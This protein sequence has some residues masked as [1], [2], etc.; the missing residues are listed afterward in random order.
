MEDR[1][2]KLRDYIC[3]IDKAVFPQNP[4]PVYFRRQK[5]S[6]PS[7]HNKRH[8]VNAAFVNLIEKTSLKVFFV[9]LLLKILLPLVKFI[10]KYAVLK[11]SAIFSVS[12]HTRNTRQKKLKIFIKTLIELLKMR[13]ISRKKI[14]YV[15]YKP[16]DV[17]KYSDAELAFIA[18]HE[19]RHRVQYEKKY[20]TMDPIGDKI[21]F[22]DFS[23]SKEILIDF[24]GKSSYYDDENIPT[25]ID[26]N[27]IGLFLRRFAEIEFGKNPTISKRQLKEFMKKGK[28]IMRWKNRGLE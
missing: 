22:D 19:V 25:E 14:Y 2:K 3:I 24:L 6:P 23:E 8:R 15:I 21:L 20:I 12:S 28:G 5:Y 11:C 1:Y 10:F 4:I 7:K 26:A 13:L 18:W 9:D 17:Y 16:S 27:F